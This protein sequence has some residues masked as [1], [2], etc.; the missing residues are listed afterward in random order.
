MDCEEFVNAKDEVVDIYEGKEPLEYVELD[1]GSGVG[2][3]N[4]SHRLREHY[5]EK[6][7][8]WHPSDDSMYSLR[9]F[10]LKEMFETAAKKVSEERFLSLKWVA[11]GSTAEESSISQ[12]WSSGESHLREKLFGEQLQGTPE[13]EKRLTEFLERNKHIFLRTDDFDFML[14]PEN[15]SI[16]SNSYLEPSSTLGFYQIKMDSGVPGFEEWSDCCISRNTQNGCLYISQF[17]IKDKLRKIFQQFEKEGPFIVKEGD[18]AF[19]IGII[20]G[21]NVLLF[22]LVFAI[23][24]SFWPRSANEWIERKRSWPTKESILQVVQGGFHFVPKSNPKGNADLDW[25]IS[26]SKAETI[27][28]YSP[29]VHW[30]THVPWRILKAL[31]QNKY[32]LQSRPKFLS[33]YI[34]KTLLFYAMERIPELYWLDADYLLKSILGIIDDLIRCLAVQNCPHYFM[35][36]INLFHRIPVDF[37]PIIAKQLVEYREKLLEDPVK[38]TFGD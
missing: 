29:L 17:L 6:Q 5:D 32:W 4:M 19:Q 16:P 34:L 15:L 31:M 10:K 8:L 21:N 25:R 7:H 18:L 1:F 20:G 24:C 26:F 14:I 37:Y 3:M 23:S 38:L 30:Y 27:L 35:P 22:D 28:T 11:S 36:Q 33:S 12:I 13:Q 2:T 9:Y